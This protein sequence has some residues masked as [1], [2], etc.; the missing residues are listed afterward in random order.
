[1]RQLARCQ[2]LGATVNPSLNANYIL[3][4]LRYNYNTVAQYS[5]FGARYRGRYLNLR[6]IVKSGI[7]VMAI[8]TT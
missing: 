7:P 8:V 3:P 6:T 1:M 5:H 4:K 2:N